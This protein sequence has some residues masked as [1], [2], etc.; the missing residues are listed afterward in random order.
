M[1]RRL[2]GVDT[3]SPRP[4]TSRWRD[5]T[6]TV[7]ATVTGNQITCSAVSRQRRH[8]HRNRHRRQ[9]RQRHDR[10]RERSTTAAQIRQMRFSQP[11]T[12]AAAG[13]LS[14]GA[15]MHAGCRAAGHG[16]A[17][18]RA[19][20]LRRAPTCSCSAARARSRGY[21]AAGAIA[22]PATS[23]YTLSAAIR[24]DG[25][26]RR[27]KVIAIESGGTTTTLASVLRHH[28]LDGVLAPPSRPSPA[29]PGSPSGCGWTAAA[30]P[31]S[32]TLAGDHAQ[33]SLRSR[34][35]RSTSAASIRCPRRSPWPSLSTPPSPPTRTGRCRFRDPATL[36]TAP[37]RPSPSVAL[38]WRVNGSGGL[39]H[40][41]HHDRA[42]GR[43]RRRQHTGRHR[44]P[45]RFPAAGDLRRPVL[46]A[47]VPDHADLRRH[48]PVRSPRC[49]D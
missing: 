41:V 2:A 21:S 25:R 11:V 46:V 31:A 37:A 4:P 24:T 30:G 36:P 35:A 12:M 5:V 34:P 14:R 29:P 22:A 33:R 9:L 1:Q 23:T 10:G 40:T 44:H 32:T 17:T 28:R 7:T 43:H 6:Y 13:A 45:A 16:A 20:Q 42:V 39:L 18:S 15:G 49:E 47:A 26:Q 27:A 19:G 38:G 48:H 8:R 3:C